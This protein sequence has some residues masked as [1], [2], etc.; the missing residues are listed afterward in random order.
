[1]LYPKCL[2]SNGRPLSARASAVAVLLRRSPDFICSRR[3]ASQYKI[4]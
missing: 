4:K 3:V 1:M 2:A